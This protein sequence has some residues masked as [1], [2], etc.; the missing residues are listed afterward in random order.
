MATRKKVRRPRAAARRFPQAN[1]LETMHQ[2]WLAGIGAASRAQVEG[3][4]LLKE[5]MTEGARVHS[6][7]SRATRKVV[8]GTFD[9]VQSGIVSRVDQVR[10]QASDA[11][12]NLE[13]IFQTRVHRALNQ[14]GVP[15][16]EEI[17]EL[18]KR[19]DAL[20]ANIDRLRHVRGKRRVVARK[21]RARP[22]RAIGEHAVA[23][24]A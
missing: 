3:P 4:K 11:I 6:Q 14:L 13:R 12:D 20:N 10:E 21:R 24:A 2:I 17:A 8:R 7:A 18:T 9:Q 5:L 22:A 19:V 16:A 1:L 23:A 15:S